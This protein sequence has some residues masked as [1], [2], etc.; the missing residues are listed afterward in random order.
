MRLRQ[1]PLALIAALAL[2]AVAG[3]GSAS[4]ATCNVKTS[5]YPGDGYFTSLRVTKVSCSTGKSVAREHYR[6]RVRRGG[7]DGKFNG[8]VKGYSCR[9]SSRSKTSTELNARVTCKRGSKRVV[10]TYQQNL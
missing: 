4:A 6:K 3:A 8:S 7:K 10:F 5:D 1:L 2:L 9:E